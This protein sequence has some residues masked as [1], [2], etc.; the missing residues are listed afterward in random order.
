MSFAEDEAPSSGSTAGPVPPQKSPRK[1]HRHPGKS[2][3]QVSWASGSEGGSGSAS[4][5]GAEAGGHFSR[6]SSIRQ[7]A[8]SQRSGFSTS[9]PSR[10]PPPVRRPKKAMADSE[11][12][13]AVN[14]VSGR[15]LFWSCVLFSSQGEMLGSLVATVTDKPLRPSHLIVF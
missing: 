15:L 9:G 3:S 10:R 7:S 4:F 14:L 8:T 12:E 6:Q 1:H 11:K 2:P 13:E 5:A